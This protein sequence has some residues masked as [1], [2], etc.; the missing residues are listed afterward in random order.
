METASGMAPAASRRTLAVDL[1]PD[2]VLTLAAASEALNISV[3]ALWTWVKVGRLQPV[4]IERRGSRT[5]TYVRCADVAAARRA[6]RLRREAEDAELRDAYFGEQLST[7]A[8]ADRTGRSPTGVAKRIKAQGLILRERGAATRASRLDSLAA[9]KEAEQLVDSKDVA[10]QVQCSPITVARHA[11]A[12]ELTSARR[13]PGD[14]R[15]WL[16]PADTA[17]REMRQLLEIGKKRSAEA[18]ALARSEGRARKVRRG[19]LKLCPC[20]CGELKYVPPA[21]ADRVVG[22]FNKWHYGAARQNRAFVP[23]CVC[24]KGLRRPLSKIK[25]N[26]RSRCRHVCA[27]CWPPLRRARVAA[28][29]RLVRA[30]AEG[31]SLSSAFMEVLEMGF[32]Y[33]KEALSSWPTGVGRRPPLA[34]NLAIEVF[35]RGGFTDGQLRQLLNGALANGALSIP[36]VTGANL[37][38]RYVERRRQQAQIRRRTSISV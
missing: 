11:R 8:I 17:V 30:L 20:G 25:A 36:G 9:F 18:I 14:R 28:D 37:N 12:G 5:T 33:E 15:T 32:R 16:F 27:T 3:S 38:K 21:H 7:S 4:R 2:E 22:Y 35:H 10:A 23:C 31:R 34:V 6:P 19:S 29:V 24:R 13:Y 26:Q 1:E